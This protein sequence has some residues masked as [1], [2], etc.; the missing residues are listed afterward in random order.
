MAS[1]F[2][3]AVTAELTVLAETPSR[4]DV[5]VASLDAD[6]MLLSG[7]PFLTPGC[8][9]KVCQQDRLWLGEVVKSESA[10]R[11]AIRVVHSLNHL[12]ELSRL[13]ERF[14]QDKLP[15]EDQITLNTRALVFADQ[16]AAHARGSDYK[17]TSPTLS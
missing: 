1:D 3:S 17:A 12:Q 6:R 10:G 4:F 7:A 16:P 8:P 14:L 2:P 15:Q 5:T 13:A 9:V 11:V